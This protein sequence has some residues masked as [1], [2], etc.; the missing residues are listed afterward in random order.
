MND[1]TINTAIETSLPVPFRGRHLI[2]GAWV[3]GAETF[4]RISPS[5]DR[6]VSVSAKGDAAVTQTAI[7]AARAPL[8]RATGAGFLRSSAAPC[9]S[10]WPI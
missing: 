7:A 2:D 10:K 6:V 8:M 5:H 3:D 4:E 1:L 9:C